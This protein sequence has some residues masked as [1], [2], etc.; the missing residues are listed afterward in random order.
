MDDYWIRK[1]NRA[2]PE[3]MLFLAA[4]SRKMVSK[5]GLVTHLD[6]VG[7]CLPRRERVNALSKEPS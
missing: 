4:L 6:V 3:G 2:V 1:N 7:Q 5:M